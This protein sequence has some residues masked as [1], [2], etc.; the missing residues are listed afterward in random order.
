MLNIQKGDTLYRANFEHSDYIEEI[1]AVDV[2][3]YND[4]RLLKVFLN[5]EH[6][7]FAMIY[8]WQEFGTIYPST[9]R[10]YP[11]MCFT[12]DGLKCYIDDRINEA[13]SVVDQYEQYKDELIKLKK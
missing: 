13:Q 7:E 10:V 11:D 3:I 1:L 9:A 4:G 6:T 12:Y 5:D 8:D 2:E